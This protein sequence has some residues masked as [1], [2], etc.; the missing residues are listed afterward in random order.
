MST[1]SIFYL[2]VT[3]FLGSELLILLAKEFP[4]FPITALLRNANP[5]RTSRIKAIHPTITIV[6]G[7]LL[8]DLLVQELAS[9]ADIV[10]NTA[11]SDVHESIMSVLAGLKKRSA[12]KPNDPPLYIHVSGLGIISDNSR[13]EYATNPKW[14][15]DIGLKLED[16]PPE[17]THLISDREIVAAATRKEDPIRSIIVYPGWIYGVGEGV[18]K[19]TLPTRVYMDMALK[20]GYAGT[21]GAG[22]NVMGEIHV[23]DVASACLVLLKAALEGKADE[24]AEG[25]Y[26][27]AT[28][29]MVPMCDI[30]SKLGDILH[31]KGLIP[32]GGSRPYPDE[33]LAPLGDFGWKLLAG[34]LMAKPERL[35]RLGWEPT[36]TLRGPSLLDSLE[37]EINAGLEEQHLAGFAGTR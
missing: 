26:F 11:S 30:M 4:N 18:Q 20:V 23:K 8:N 29:N 12:N 32:E 7:D 35:A 24:G 27:T 19:L 31:E 22:K 17:N 1:P 33:V 25:F 16:C 14:Y 37:A 28:T 15:S 36:V 13:G 5:E 34:S 2:G 3:G 9:K 6:E 10:I 21:W